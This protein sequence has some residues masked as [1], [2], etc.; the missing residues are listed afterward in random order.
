[1]VSLWGL[2]G[3]KLRLWPVSAN[4]YLS[5]SHKH[6]LPSS[7]FRLVFE[8]YPPVKT[9]ILVLLILAVTANTDTSSNS[10]FRT[11]RTPYHGI[12]RSIN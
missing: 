12:L 10:F 1:M 11:P 5:F 6:S 8:P 4:F 9:S 3:E 7:H 2:Y